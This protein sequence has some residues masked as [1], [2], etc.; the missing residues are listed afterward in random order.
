LYLQAELSEAKWPTI[1]MKHFCTFLLLLLFW[2]IQPHT[3]WSQLVMDDTNPPNT[4]PGRFFAGEGVRISNV[5]PFFGTWSNRFRVDRQVGLFSKSGSSPAPFF[6]SGI[7]MTTGRLVSIPNINRDSAVTENTTGANTEFR[8]P[9][10][11][12]L[13]SILASRFPGDREQVSFDA[14][15]LEFDFIPDYDTVCFNYIFASEEYTEYSTSSQ[16]FNDIFTFLIKGPGINGWKNLALV[17]GSTEIVSAGTI[18]DIRNP[19]FFFDNQADP[20]NGITEGPY[21]INFDGF[22]TVLTAQTKLIPCRTYTLRIAIADVKD[23]KFDSG[24]FLQSNSL[25]SP[26][27]DSTEVI[28]GLTTH[29]GKPASYESC[30][31]D[32]ALVFHRTELDSA[33]IYP[34]ILSGTAQFSFEYT[35]E[36]EEVRFARGQRSDTVFIRIQQDGRAE[37]PESIIFTYQP[38]TACVPLVDT[39]W[40]LDVTPTLTLSKKFHVICSA[41]GD[42]A[43]RVTATTAPVFAP[44]GYQFVWRNR[45]NVVVGSNPTLNLNINRDTTI[46]L[47]AS[48][49][50]CDFP[51]LRDTVEVRFFNTLTTYRAS[52][53]TTICPGGT[54]TLRVFPDPDK[55]DFRFLWSTG[56]T[57]QSI[58]VRPSAASSYTV[59]IT[60]PCT[61]IVR[62]IAVQLHRLTAA[63]IQAPAQVC[64][65]TSARLIALPRLVNA[66]GTRPLLPF[67]YRWEDDG[68]QLLGT[69]SI[70]TLPNVT[71]NRTIR[72]QIQDACSNS[73]RLQHSLRLFDT[74]NVRPVRDTFACAGA[75]F[76]LNAQATGAGTLRY[77]WFNSAIND[78]ISTTADLNLPPLTNTLQLG[79][80][81]QDNCRTNVQLFRLRVVPL[82]LRLD[83]VLQNVNP[84]VCQGAA[85]RLVAVA[86]R[87]SGQYRYRWDNVL[88][89]STFDV[90]IN[91]DRT[92]RLVLADG[93]ST[94]FKDIPYRIHPALAV[95]LPGSLQLCLG[96]DTVF[97]LQPT[98]GDG[99]Y[100]YEWLND[101]SGVLLARTADLALTVRG[102]TILRGCVTDGCNTRVCDVLRITTFPA[103][104]LPL[105][106]DLTLCTGVPFSRRLDN[107][108]GAPPLDVQ[109]FELPSNRLLGTGT[110]LLNQIFSDTTQIR[111]QVRD[112]CFASNRQT[113]AD[114]FEVRVIPDN[115]ALEQLVVS[116]GSPT[117]T[118][119]QVS[120]RAVASGGDPAS[121][122]FRWDGFPDTRPTLQLANTL[123]RTVVVRV[124][125]QCGREVSR[126]TNLEVFPPLVIAPLNDTTICRNTRIRVQAVPLGGSGEYVT[127]QWTNSLDQ[128]V[129]LTPVID[130]V[131]LNSQVFL[132]TVRDSCGVER[133]ARYTIRVF[134]PLVLESI[135]DT[136]VCVNRL[137]ITLRADVISSS[138]AST[139]SYTWSALST[140]TVV[141]RLPQVRINDPQTAQYSL[142][143]A[144]RC[145]THTDTFLVNVIQND[146]RFNGFDITPDQDTFCIGQRVNVSAFVQGGSRRYSFRWAH[147]YVGAS[148]DTLLTRTTFLAVTATDGCGFTA[149]SNVRIPVFTP[150][151]VSITPDT[152]V[153]ELTVLRFRPQIAGGRWPYRRLAWLDANNRQVGSQLILPVT[154]NQ[155]TTYRFVVEDGCGDRDT[156]QIRLN[157]LPAPRLNLGVDITMCGG[158]TVQVLS[159]I[160]PSTSCRVEWTPTFGLLNPLVLQPLASPVSSTRYRARVQCNGCW[161]NVD[162]IAVIVIARPTVSILAQSLQ[163]C[164]AD[165]GV[166]IRLSPLSFHPQFRYEWRPQVGLS[167]IFSPEPIAR[168]DTTTTYTLTSFTVNSPCSIS[169]SV[170]VV[171]EPNPRVFIAGDTAFCAGDRGVRL[172]TLISFTGFGALEYRWTPAAGLSSTTIANPVAR[173]DSTTIYRFS[174]RNLQTGCPGLGDSTIRVRV[175]PR[176]VANAGPDQSFCLGDTLTIGINGPDSLNYFWTPAFGLNDPRIEQPTVVLD[177]SM[178]YFLQV[179]QPGCLSN[180]DSVNVRAFTRPTLSVADGVEICIGDSTTL[181]AILF[182]DTVSSSTYEWSPTSTLSDSSIANPV[183]KP[184]S[185]TTYTVRV[186]VPYCRGVF[187]DSAQV[188]IKPIP[189]LL[190]R[191][192]TASDDGINMILGDSIILP[193]QITSAWP[194]QVQWIPSYF[195]QD[196]SLLQPMVYPT[197]TIVYYMNVQVGDCYYQDSVKVNVIFPV[198]VTVDVDKR[199]ICAGDTVQLT[200]VGTRQSYLRY[201]WFQNDTLLPW[202]RNPQFKTPL[203]RNTRFTVVI[204]DSLSRQRDTA[205][206]SVEVIPKPI[207]RFRGVINRRCGSAQIA[208]LDS[209]FDV[210]QWQWRIPELD[211]VSN[212]QHPRFEIYRPDTY[213]VQLRGVSRW[214]CIDSLT[215]AFPVDFIDT[216]AV[217][218]Q[219]WTIPENIDTL[220]LPHAHVR[221]KDSTNHAVQWLWNFGDT[222]HSTDSIAKHTYLHPGNYQIELT[223]IDSNDCA[224]QT[225]FK[226]IYVL[227]PELEI[228]DAF[229]PNGDNLNDA[230]RIFYQGSDRVQIQV[231]N[232]WG[233]VVYRTN[234]PNATWNGR[235]FN[236]GQPLPVGVYIYHIVVGDKA[237]NG[238]VSILQ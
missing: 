201:A 108:R 52:R 168:P 230:W 125:D 64:R 197:D 191:G 106:Q 213:R 86:S 110:A 228:P 162:S 194:Y 68:G 136:T 10:D 225:V 174:V 77:R 61:T 98:G 17:P 67:S 208:L 78:T 185:T 212:E 206:V 167:N 24:I 36:R 3:G 115:L 50:E 207:I 202:Q 37:G 142:V 139:Q 137:P 205:E 118:G 234:D 12:V 42:T 48:Y 99:Q 221:M 87:G 163:R 184:D 114:T 43:I 147:G 88:G 13:D 214:G 169:D 171:V 148:V 231:F 83:T 192:D 69:D 134:D 145:S 111:I 100:R 186:S 60:D 49:P 39:V 16:R 38:R 117:C 144:D 211:T 164:A 20:A 216:I 19:E 133:T 35:L 224:G 188:V 141:S 204:E 166:Q 62:T 18:N 229:S 11:P 219:V 178:R 51:V 107:L 217:Q 123:N 96:A 189:Q 54:A 153:C 200:A 181:Q 187:V 22:T 90:T 74:L 227:Q 215:I 105:Q 176:P 28:G 203:F 29:L 233:S 151:Q 76:N 196:S 140:N 84:P 104:N 53:D 14:A 175:V 47:E 8:A 65:G 160:T 30:S 210:V 109:W 94:V 103:L 177:Q 25:R 32:L 161:S 55:L 75:V 155:T 127:T 193:A 128:V 182:P 223:V 71:A 80:L 135:G 7:V 102:D 40:I 235:D 93:C 66:D 31:E 26:K 59:T 190:A 199:R 195:M 165:S 82:D 95:D 218:A 46:F 154:A 157:V 1:G 170:K 2:V 70:L 56:E 116:P 237:Y 91:A 5:R 57:T 150:V 126:S 27:K 6:P 198:F 173:P 89:P 15:V 33:V 112:Q 156:T 209:S 172:P 226:P 113:L 23:F 143:V 9:G 120:I 159:R 130:T 232:R 222:Y 79:L 158:D 146:M 101:R 122:A 138:G 236:S 85:V 179:G 132:F 119:Q 73:V 149:N 41:P 21:A 34:I 129:S 44:P 180:A 97:R 124:R 131:L 183:A 81:V 45:Q 238:M 220:R 121:Y 152:T 72:L 58:N 4:I 92:I 63:D